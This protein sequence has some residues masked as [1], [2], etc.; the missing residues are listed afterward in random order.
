MG[1][2][3]TSHLIAPAGTSHS[4]AAARRADSSVKGTGWEQGA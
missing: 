3:S 1:L 4:K 2:S